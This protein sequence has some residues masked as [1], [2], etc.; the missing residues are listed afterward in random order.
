MFCYCKMYCPIFL[1][2]SK[3]VSKSNTYNCLNVTSISVIF[4]RHITKKKI[5]KLSPSKLYFLQ[6]GI[7]LSFQI[8]F[9]Q[10]QFTDILRWLFPFNLLAVIIVVTITWIKFDFFMENIRRLILSET[11]HFTKNS[12]WCEFYN[13][14]NQW[15]PKVSQNRPKLFTSIGICDVFLLLGWVLRGA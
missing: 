5:R 9:I 3:I 14:H 8:N 12:P 11:K 15:K 13:Q 2:K 6:P 10:I 7:L 1:M 4:S